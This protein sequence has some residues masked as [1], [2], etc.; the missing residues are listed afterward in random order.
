M[1]AAHHNEDSDQPE[2]A[3]TA[4]FWDDRYGS[5]ERI[6]SGNPNAQ[7]VTVAT[8]L[9]PGTALDVGCGEGADAVWLAGRGWRVTGVDVSR[10]ALDRAA[11]HAAEAGVAGATAWQQVDIQVWVPPAGEYDLVSAHFMQMPPEVRDGMHA[12]MAAAV[13]PGGTLLV[14]GH[15]FSDLDTSVRRPHRHDLMFTA[16]EVA[17]VLDPEEWEIETSTPARTT[18]DPDGE[19]VTIHDAVMRAVRRR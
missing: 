18:T 16:E 19:T 4:E 1:S 13:R 6:W 17:A 9:T 2:V 5:A 15:H 7:L 3:F 14:V 11:A 12:G 8:P 10:V